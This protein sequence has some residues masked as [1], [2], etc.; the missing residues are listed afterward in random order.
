MNR[1]RSRQIRKRDSDLAQRDVDL[2]L[3]RICRWP[4]WKQSSLC[5]RSGMLGV[6]PCLVWRAQAAVAAVRPQLDSSWSP[7]I[8]IVGISDLNSSHLQGVMC[9]I[10]QSAAFPGEDQTFR[11]FTTSQE[12]GDIA[13]FIRKHLEKGLAAHSNVLAW[14]ITWTGEPGGLQPPWG[15][16]QS[17]TTK[18]LT[19]THTHQ[20]AH[21]LEF[22]EWPWVPAPEWREH[23]CFYFRVAGTEDQQHPHPS[24]HHWFQ[25]N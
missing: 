17:D 14:N 5:A 10:C 3:L 16:R 1:W 20:E 15:R 19:H 11:P 4:V 25:F 7:P 13:G 2:S 24:W 23:I 8:L 9:F 18:Q 21:W 12:S 6:L 22:C